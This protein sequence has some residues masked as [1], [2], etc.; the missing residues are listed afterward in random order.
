VDLRSAVRA[1]RR[2]TAPHARRGLQAPAG[3][4]SIL[5]SHRFSTVRTADLIVV[6]DGSR[7]VESGS[8]EELMAHGGTYAQLYRIK[9]AAYR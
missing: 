9:A 7:V 5:V 3:R 1:V 8:H 2:G 4:I 6:L